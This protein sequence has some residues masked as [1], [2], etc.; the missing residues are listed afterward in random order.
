[1]CRNWFELCWMPSQRGISQCWRVCRFNKGRR[2]HLLSAIHIY[3]CAKHGGDILTLSRGDEVA[4]NPISVGNQNITCY[5]RRSNG[6]I[7]KNYPKKRQN[8]G[9]TT[10]KAMQSI[11]QVNATV[12][13]KWIV[14]WL[15]AGTRTRTMSELVQEGRSKCGCSW[16][17]KRCS[18]HYMPRHFNRRRKRGWMM[19]KSIKKKERRMGWSEEDSAGT[20]ILTHSFWLLEARLVVGWLLWRGG[21]TGSNA[22]ATTG[23]GNYSSIQVHR[24]GNG[25]SGR[26][27][28]VAGCQSF[29]FLTQQPWWIVSATGKEWKT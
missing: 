24:N 11:S 21:R 26:S 17:S 22:T 9:V 4:L 18:G 27:D 2:C 3:W 7:A 15:T 20:K 12:A 10:A 29:Y 25:I 16:H 8:N 19:D 1:M 5:K 23:N 13:A 14:K 6:H 28:S